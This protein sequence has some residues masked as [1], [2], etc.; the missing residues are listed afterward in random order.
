MK[1][2]RSGSFCDQGPVRQVHLRGLQPSRQRQ[3][4]HGPLREPDRNLSAGLRQHESER[5]S[6]RQ[7]TVDIFY[8]GLHCYSGN[9]NVQI[10]Q[11]ERKKTQKNKIKRLP[12][13]LV[14]VHDI[15]SKCNCF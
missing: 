14:Q 6:E 5:C 2:S 15:S 11:K 8:L 10:K 13:Y 7:N 3:P 1:L 4:A 9:A 12:Q